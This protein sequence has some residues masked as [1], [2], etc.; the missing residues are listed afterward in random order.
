MAGM[1]AVP[2]WFVGGL[3]ASGYGLSSWMRDGWSLELSRWCG[4]AIVLLGL[5][6]CYFRT[7]WLATV[8]RP[9]G[10]WLKVLGW[11]LILADVGWMIA[12]V[13]WP[14]GLE[15]RL[16]TLAMF[17]PLLVWIHVLVRRE[18]P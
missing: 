7:V 14:A 15:G 9:L 18:L 3:A 12:T 8:G 13:G 11:L 17:A 2:Y 16:M 5:P 4:M 6:I 1:F 10:P